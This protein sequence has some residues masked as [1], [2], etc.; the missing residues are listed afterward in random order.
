MNEATQ[1][2]LAAKNSLSNEFYIQNV[3]KDVRE[4]FD[5]SDEL[6]LLRKEIALL[7]NEIT[8]LIHK[9]LDDA[10]FMEYNNKVEDIKAKH[11]MN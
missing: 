5:S 2:K 3:R 7:R 1:K 10:E 8:K 4:T 6:A 9:E 11:K